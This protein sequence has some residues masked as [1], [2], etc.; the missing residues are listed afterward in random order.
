RFQRKYGFY[1]IYLFFSI[2]Y[3]GVLFALPPEWRQTAAI[4]MIF[5]D[6][7][8]MGLYFMGAIVLFEKSERVLNSV[9]ISPVKPYEYVLS[10]LF[11]IG[12]ISTIVA[13]AIG[14]SSDV[15]IRPF[16]F[17]TGVFL[18]SCL[19]SAIGLIFACKIS[20]LNQF[21]IATIPAELLINVPAIAWLLGYRKSW[22]LLH[23]GVCLIELL[24]DSSSILPAWII[25]LG[26]TLLFAVLS[27]RIVRKMLRSVGGVKL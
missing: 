3:I 7:A 25:L 13:V 14:V 24:R 17:I 8:A 26:W 1:Y 10:K 12:C 11:S 2:L 22:L 16:S 20:S 5:S 23:P 19:F 21:V 27:E 15:I 6:P 18:C 9:A 4:L